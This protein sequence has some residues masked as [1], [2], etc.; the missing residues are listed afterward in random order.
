MDDKDMWE[1]KEEFSYCNIGGIIVVWLVLQRRRIEKGHGRMSL[2]FDNCSVALK[3][4][5][6]QMKLRKD[7]IDSQDIWVHIEGLPP[8]FLNKEIG[9]T[10]GD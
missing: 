2:I 6:E 8:K 4:T 3:E 10:I 9:K 5:D 7:V 1:I